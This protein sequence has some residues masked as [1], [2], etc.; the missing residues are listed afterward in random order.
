M[1]D[2][3]V[4]RGSIRRMPGHA[5]SI[6]VLEP[7]TDPTIDAGTELALTMYCDK[8]GLARAAVVTDALREYFR[9]HPMPGAER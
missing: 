4:E 7:G 2:A 5:R 3:L 6:E 9:A 8:T 1:V